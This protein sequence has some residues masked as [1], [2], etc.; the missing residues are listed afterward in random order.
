M[1]RIMFA[2]HGP[3]AIVEIPLFGELLSEFS[4]FILCVGYLHECKIGMFIMYMIVYIQDESV[5]E[6]N[7]IALDDEEEVWC[8]NVYELS[9]YCTV[10]SCYVLCF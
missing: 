2:I 1:R 5:G 9:D 3:N 8:I 6:V 4:P 7:R 10:W